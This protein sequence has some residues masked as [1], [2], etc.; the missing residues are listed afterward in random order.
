MLEAKKA[1][2]RRSKSKEY[3]QYFR[4]HGID[5]LFNQDESISE[6][7]TLYGYTVQSYLPEP[8]NSLETLQNVIDNSFDFLHAS[9]ILEHATDLERTIKNWIRVV[10]PGGYLVITVPDEEM[11]EKNIWPSKF[12]IGHKWSFN[13]GRTTERTSSIDV[14]RWFDDLKIPGALISNLKRITDGY[15]ETDED[16]T[17]KPNVIAECGIEIVIYKVAHEGF[18]PVLDWNLNGFCFMLN[19]LAMGDVIAAV[20]VVKY[21]VERFYTNP[22]SYLVVAKEMFRSLFWFIPDSNF[23]NFEDKTNDWGIPKNWAIGVLNQKKEQ[24]TGIIRNTPKAIHL[25]QFASMKLVDKL[26]PMKD[27]N[28]VGLP[29]VDVSHFNIDFSKAVI[30]ISSYRDLTRMWDQQYILEVA[31]WLKEKGLTPVFIG[32]TDM[33]LDTHLIPKT[34]LPANV[35]EYGI[36]LRNKTSVEELAS[37]MALSRA[38][39]GLDSGPIH[40]AGTTAVPIVCGYTSVS[41]EYRIPIRSKGITIPVM[42]DIPCNGC[43]SNWAANFWNYEHCYFGTNECCKQMTSDKFIKALIDILVG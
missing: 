25:G 34:S 13:F 3:N 30:L 1:M 8:G 36:D 28:Y 11:Y 24:G 29:T 7:K 17:A 19:S 9:H 33:N 21:M 22:D 6:C 5:L 18:K 23:R 26:L 37:I 43:E 41:P 16:L 2:L 38:V 31:T 20:P 12:N 39:V 42:A 27:L 4:G 10:K 40:L 15:Y 14:T 35:D 32:K